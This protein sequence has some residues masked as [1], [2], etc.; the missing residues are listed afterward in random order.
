MKFGERIRNFLTRA[1]RASAKGSGSGEEKDLRSGGN[2]LW[3]Y[4]TSPALCVATAYRCISLLSDKVANLPL[5]VKRKSGNIFTEDDRGN[6]PFLLNVEPDPATSAFDFRK[7]IA[8]E[9]LCAGNAYIVPFYSTASGDWERIV[10]C[11]RGTV[12]HDT[13]TDTYYVSDYAN[14]V[15]GVFDE[16]QIIHIKGMPGNDMKSGV[17]VLSYARM[18]L[19]TAK[20]GDKESLERFDSGGAVKGL[21]SIKDAGQTGSNAFLRDNEKESARIARS[22]DLQQREVNIMALPGEY[23]FQQFSLSSVDMQFLE[24]RKFTVREICR[25]FGVHPSFVFDDTSNN[26]KSAEMAN[27]S[28]LSDTLDPMLSKIENEFLRKLFPRKLCMKRKI[29]FD[30]QGLYACDLDSKVKY[31]GGLIGAGICTVNEA[32]AMEGREPVEGGDKV[33]VSANLK[34]IDELTKGNNVKGNGEE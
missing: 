2:P 34:G 8:I 25:F 4:S 19:S 7:Q 30:R 32:R 17:S 5:A 21:L 14:G 11:G 29:V 28:F 23:S 12:N 13:A 27:V 15:Y 16:S 10:L 6:L 20:A 31:I 18:S 3:L 1:K 22:L 26:Y 9:V 24:S 33:L